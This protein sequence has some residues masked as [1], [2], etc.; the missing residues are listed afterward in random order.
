[1]IE[2]QHPNDYKL[3][4]NQRLILDL[5]LGSIE[6]ENDKEHLLKKEIEEIEARG[7]MVD[8]PFE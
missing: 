3:P 2:N 6:P 4:E 7:N 1:M 5:A 8:L